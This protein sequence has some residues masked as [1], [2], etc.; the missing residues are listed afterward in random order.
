MLFIMQIEIFQL[1]SLN[2]SLF[3]AIKKNIAFL[4]QIINK[5]IEKLPCSPRLREE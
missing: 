3:K 1:E 4:D 2:L 5:S